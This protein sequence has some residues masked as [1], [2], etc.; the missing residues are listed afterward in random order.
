MFEEQIACEETGEEKTEETRGNS[1]LD[2]QHLVEPVNV[3][4]S[5]RV[6]GSWNGGEA[7]DGR[8]RLGNLGTGMAPGSAV[9]LDCTMLKF[10]E[11][12]QGKRCCT[13][14]KYWK[15]EQGK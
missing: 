14:L 11:L 4:A 13:M 2:A 1:E 3:T 5:R 15:L 7:P 12:R 6:L 10:W 8:A 9:G